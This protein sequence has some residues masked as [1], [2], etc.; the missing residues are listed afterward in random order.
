MLGMFHLVCG[1]SCPQCELFSARILGP[2]GLRY[3]FQRESR[4]CGNTDTHADS[5]QLNYQFQE[6]RRKGSHSLTPTASTSSHC[7]KISGLQTTVAGAWPNKSEPLHPTVVHNS[8]QNS[9][10]VAPHNGLLPAFRSRSQR[11]ASRNPAS[12][13]PAPGEDAALVEAVAAAQLS[14]TLVSRDR[15][16]SSFGH[17]R[18]SIGNTGPQ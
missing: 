11:L 7:A 15:L 13:L 17:Y 3:K 6:V 9:V 18:Y 10:E 14:G 2:F 12:E 4:G 16:L 1:A 5:Q 8:L